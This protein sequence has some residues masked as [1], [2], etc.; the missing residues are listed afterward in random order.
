[1][2]LDR[3]L[4]LA[5]LS[6][7][8][9]EFFRN[10][11]R[12]V[13][14]AHGAKSSGKTHTIRRMCL[15]LHIFTRWHGQLKRKSDAKFLAAAYSEP[16]VRKNVIEPMAEFWNQVER[17]AVTCKEGE[18][19]VFGATVD[20][21]GFTDERS[22]GRIQG[23]TYAGGY[24]TEGTLCPKNFWQTFEEQ[25]RE[26]EQ[27]GV[28]CIFLDTNP[29][30]AEHWV[31]RELIDAA[32]R[33]D[34]IYE[35]LWL[36]TQEFNPTL[37]LEHIARNESRAKYDPIWHARMF[38]GQWINAEGLVYPQFSHDENIVETFEPKRDGVKLKPERAIGVD[39][40]TSGVCTFSLAQ[41]FRELDGGTMYTPKEYYWDA[42]QAGRMK[43]DEE[44]LND[45]DAFAYPHGRALPLVVDQ[46]ATNFHA[47]ARNRGW[48][49]V[50]AQNQN[51]DGGIR[52]MTKAIAERRMLWNRA[53]RDTIREMGLYS[54]DAK[55]TARGEDKPLK[56]NDH[57][58]DRD[59]YLWLY[60]FGH[61][62]LTD[63][64]I[65]RCHRYLPI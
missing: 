52:Q 12:R 62:R 8:G 47:A 16:L 33:D 56:K 7:K 1:M 19:T 32:Q 45:L 2:N 14:I 3:I 23:T 61:Q 27:T 25:C 60:F 63:E 49:V 36:Q 18:A 37:T 4:E 38:L 5:K 54:W 48:K 26:S 28:N 35:M 9:L 30:P 46:K 64:F 59:R 34:E 41:A 58:M 24:I 51:V 57:A 40:G 53:C 11:S 50:L 13:N 55:A 21:V 65:A 39:Y 15:P 6:P 22:V 29:G 44:Y 42:A 10:A 20:L 31:K 17:D 43:S